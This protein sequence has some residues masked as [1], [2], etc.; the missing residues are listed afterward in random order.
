MLNLTETLSPR[1]PPPSGK[2]IAANFTELTACDEAIRWVRNTSQS[3]VQIRDGMW[4]TLCEY[5]HRI[6]I[7]TLEVPAYRKL[8]D[9]INR[10][11]RQL[12][13]VECKL[14]DTSYLQK[15]SAEFKMMEKIEAGLRFVVAEGLEILKFWNR[16]EQ[17]QKLGS[18]LS[19]KDRRMRS[20]AI[21]DSNCRVEKL[22]K[23]AEA[24]EDI[25]LGQ[26]LLQ[27]TLRKEYFVMYIRMRVRPKSV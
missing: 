12:A 23:R 16:R 13:L 10:L 14:A 1:T 20:I 22:R 17:S 3:L 19:G 11:I 25:I 9:V 8:R 6:L 5:F 24:V 21:H 2:T 27:D 18:S 26:E 7:H 4:T 15:D